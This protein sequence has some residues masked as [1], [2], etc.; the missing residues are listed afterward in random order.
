MEDQTD[1][2]G[3]VL[4]RNRAILMEKN[5]GVFNSTC[6]HD[7]FTCACQYCHFHLAGAWKLCDESARKRVFTAFE[8]GGDGA[9]FVHSSRRCDTNNYIFTIHIFR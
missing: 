6:G 4:R 8:R 7:P 9:A 1:L 5:L 2:A 3:A